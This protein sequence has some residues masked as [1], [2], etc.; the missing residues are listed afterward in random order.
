MVLTIPE[1]GGSA[2]VGHAVLSHQISGVDEP[3]SPSLR[4]Q[5]QAEGCDE[6]TEVAAVGGG[7]R[8]QAGR[9][10]DRHNGGVDEAELEV[11]ILAVQ[12]VDATIAVARKIDDEVVAAVDRYSPGFTFPR[13][14]PLAPRPSYVIGDS[15]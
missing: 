13:P 4:E 8:F 1:S 7:D 6:R 5:S 10:G 3:P 11:G 15:Q 2:Q 12:L 9:S 14:S